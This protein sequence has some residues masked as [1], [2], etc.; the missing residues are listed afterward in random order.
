MGH[1]RSDYRPRIA[2]A[3]FAELLAAS[4]AVLVE[5]ARAVGKTEMAMQA[6]A[7]HVLLDVDLDAQRPVAWEP[8]AVGLTPKH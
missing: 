7:S 2:D 1:K 5:G 8:G 6:S 4:R 3:E